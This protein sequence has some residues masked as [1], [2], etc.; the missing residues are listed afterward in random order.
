MQIT[1]GG[2]LILDPFH[3]TV[4]A[5]FNKDDIMSSNLLDAGLRQLVARALRRR[6]R[7]WRDF[8]DGAVFYG[9]TWT[10]AS[11]E[12]PFVEVPKLTDVD[13]DEDDRL[14]LTG[15]ARFRASP[16]QPLIENS[17]KLRTRLGTRESGQFIRLQDPELAIGLECPKDWELK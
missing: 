15:R 4:S 13:F 12:A 8:F 9:R 10:M 6:V 16:D 11:V 7:S 1:P 3:V 5:S 14:I 17:F 2:P